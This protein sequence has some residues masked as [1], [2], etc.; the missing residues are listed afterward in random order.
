[1]QATLAN[2]RTLF[3]EF[4]A[5]V[6]TDAQV[7]FALE[8][9]AEQHRCSENAQLYLAAHTIQLWKEDGMLDGTGTTESETVGQILKE[10]VGDLEVSY[11]DISKTAEI[12]DEYYK[13][14]PYGRQYL[15]LK[16]AA[17]KKFTPRVF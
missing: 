1:M 6:A 3:P 13:R 5:P 16:E 12:G 7:E 11:S 9:A 17:V 8:L 10:K 14:T 15:A 2:F 4:D